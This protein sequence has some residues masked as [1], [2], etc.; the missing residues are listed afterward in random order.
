MQASLKEQIW[1]NIPHHVQFTIIYS[2]SRHS[3]PEWVFLLQNTKD[4]LKIVDNQT[5]L[6]MIF[7]SLHYFWSVFLNKF[8]PLSL[9]CHVTVLTVHC[10]YCLSKKLWNLSYI[11]IYIYEICGNNLYIYSLKKMFPH[12]SRPD[13]QQHCFCLSNETVEL[14]KWLES[15]SES[16]Q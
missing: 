9:F 10:F 14:H 13:S 8:S 7:F 1:M 11:Y 16:I 15:Y 5:A 12:I 2:P 3:G 6:N 4:V